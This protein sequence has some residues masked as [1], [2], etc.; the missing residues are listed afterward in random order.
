M[1]ETKKD[2]QIS[3][4]Y[5]PVNTG[6][7]PILITGSHRS[8][9][10]WVGKMLALSPAAGYI[11]EPFNPKSGM[12]RPVFNKWF[13][14]VCEENESVYRR[15]VEECLNF[16]FSLYRKT[17][18]IRS[19]RDAGRLLRDKVVYTRRRWSNLRPLVK[20]PISI[21]SAGWLAGRFNMDVVVLIRHPAAF[22]GSLKAAGWHHPFHHFLR[23]PLL[24][25]HHLKDFKEE[26][27]EYA[28]RDQPLVD[29]AIL[30]WKLIYSTIWT[31]REKYGSEWIFVRHEDLSARP[32]E[33][34]GNLYGKL[35]LDYTERIRAKIKEF[36]F[37]PG[38]PAPLKRD[39]QSNIWQWKSRLSQEEITRIKEQTQPWARRFYPE[40][41]WYR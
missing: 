16:R 22:A 41:G 40:G 37:S 33:E 17:K 28:E 10:T 7:N 38:D 21:F 4:L 31:Y 36:S 9:S 23:Q 14:Y 8:G 2:F 12:G 18:S 5:K 15:E 35:G 27:T 20:D 1:Q 29:Q 25:E 30:L 19:W 34:F 6:K 39:S 26:I 3:G 24:T 32:V 13:T 11:H